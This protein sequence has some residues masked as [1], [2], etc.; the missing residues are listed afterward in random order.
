[1]WDFFISFN[2]LL[3]EGYLSSPILEALQWMKNLLSI[4]LTIQVTLVK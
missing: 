2:F 1:M 3:Y 4:G